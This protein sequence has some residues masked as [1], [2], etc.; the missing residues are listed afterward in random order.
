MRVQSY[1]KNLFG[2]ARFR[3]CQDYNEMIRLPSDLPATTDP[4]TMSK[5]RSPVK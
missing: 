1:T 5:I 2:G 4:T 3:Y